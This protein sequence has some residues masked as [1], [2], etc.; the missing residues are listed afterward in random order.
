[1][2]NYNLIFQFSGYSYGWQERW[3]LN[4]VAVGRALIVGDAFRLAR[5]TLMGS[6]VQLTRWVIRDIDV[7]NSAFATS[8]ATSAASPI[9]GEEM[10]TPWNSVL[11]FPTGGG[12]AYRRRL[13]LRGVPD[14]AITFDAAGAPFLSPAFKNLITAFVT[15]GNV[16]NIGWRVQNAALLANAPKQIGGLA[17]DAIGRVQIN[18]PAHGFT[19]GTKIGVSKV[20][21]LNLRQQRP[22]RKS[23]NGYW[24]VAAVLDANNFSIAL[25]VYTL[26]GTPVWKGKGQAKVIAQTFVQMDSPAL[27][28]FEWRFAKK[29]TGRVSNIIRGKAPVGFRTFD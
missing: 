23:V 25:P 11:V 29:S 5:Q 13:W 24:T 7:R 14:G 15:V 16:N 28:G 2:P 3:A 17:V 19:V 21:G 1:M 18:C 26:T 6:S 4:G 27:A 22:G 12:A 8:L 10:D 20:T 9:V